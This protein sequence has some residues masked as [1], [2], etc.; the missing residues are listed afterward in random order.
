MALILLNIL[1]MVNFA[2]TAHG[3]GPLVGALCSETGF[4]GSMLNSVISMMHVLHYHKNP[5]KKI[6]QLPALGVSVKS[7]RLVA[8]RLGFSYRSHHTK[9][10]NSIHSFRAR[11]KGCAKGFVYVLFVM[12]VP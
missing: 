1:T 10:F 6:L 4:A 12:Y 11:R 8:G 5:K 7:V 9:D 3:D 2:G